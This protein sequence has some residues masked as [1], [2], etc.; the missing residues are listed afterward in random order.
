[1]DSMIRP[2]LR[3]EGV[4]DADGVHSGFLEDPSRSGVRGSLFGRAC[5]TSA[6][7]GRTM[8]KYEGISCPD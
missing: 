3:Y 2:S 8:M 6:W 7:L 1:M 5:M 4:L